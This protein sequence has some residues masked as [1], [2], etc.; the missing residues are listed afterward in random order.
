VKGRTVDREDGRGRR[1]PT[2][3]ACLVISDP[4]V[5]PKLVRDDH[6]GQPSSTLAGGVAEKDACVAAD[7]TDLDV[8]IC[9]LCRDAPLIWC[10]VTEFG[11]CGHVMPVA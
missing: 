7:L 1:Q 6:G 9:C 3:S 2:S 8:L 11:P 10:P 4:I 5:D